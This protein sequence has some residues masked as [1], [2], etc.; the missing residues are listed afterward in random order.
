MD[1]EKLTI[2]L[3]PCTNVEAG[4]ALDQ[5]S[6]AVRAGEIWSIPPSFAGSVAMKLP[7][8]EEEKPVEEAKTE[9]KTVA[10]KA[11]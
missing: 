10:K 3:G 9:K 1:I 4:E 5:I 8:P 7:E 11:K 6:R 2:T